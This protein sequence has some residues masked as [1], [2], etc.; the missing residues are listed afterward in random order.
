MSSKMKRMIATLASLAALALGGSA[1]ASATEGGSSS[2]SQST[3]E[4]E[5]SSEAENDGAAQAAACKEAGVDPNAENV[6][7]EDETGTCALGSG[8]SDDE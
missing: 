5:V 1:I 2:E 3:T 7:Y 6:E 4:Q 8:G